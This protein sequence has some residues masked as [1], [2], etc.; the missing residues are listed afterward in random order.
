MELAL[1]PHQGQSSVLASGSM[2]A[3]VI[4]CDPAVDLSTGGGSDPSSVQCSRFGCQI[5]HLS[6]F[7]QSWLQLV[8]LNT[9]RVLCGNSQGNRHSQW[10]Q[11]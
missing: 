9:Q 3:P 11:L 6:V 5:R 4:F 7:L 10:V 8:W 1:P 2:T